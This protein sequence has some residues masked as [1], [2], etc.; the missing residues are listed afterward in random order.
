MKYETSAGLPTRGLTYSKM[1]DHLR[2]AEECAA[3]MAHLQVRSWDDACWI[4]H[5]SLLPQLIQMND[6]T[7]T[8]N[9][10]NRL[11]WT[12]PAPPGDVGPMAMKL[13]QAFLNGLPLYFTEKLPKLGTVGSCALV[14]WSRYVIGM[15]LDIQIDVSPHYAFRNNQLAWRVVARCDG[16]PW[17]SGA[18]VDAEGYSVSPFVQLSA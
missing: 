1:L 16:K 6:Y 14:D 12:N 7:G 15:R 13:P 11:V 3:M 9:V 10:G 2:E 5:Q 8:S 18:I 17:L 4:M